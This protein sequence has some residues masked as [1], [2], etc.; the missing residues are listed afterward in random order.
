MRHMPA[1]L[2][3]RIEDGITTAMDNRF[4]DASAELRAHL[5]ALSIIVSLFN[6]VREPTQSMVEALE[7]LNTAIEEGREQ[8]RDVL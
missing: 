4:M 6:N 7:K 5:D 1:N 2:L 8:I 3:D